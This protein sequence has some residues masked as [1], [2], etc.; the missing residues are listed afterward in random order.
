MD[1]SA[2][3][4]SKN[5]SQRTVQVARDKT[6]LDAARAAGIEIHATCGSRGRCRSCR[7][8][9]LKGAA[10][11]PTVQDSVQLGHDEVHEGFR[12]ACQTRMLG[13]TTIRA[14][15]PKEE[16]GHQILHSSDSQIEGRGMHIESGV[17]KRVIHAKAPVEEHHQT[18]DIEEILSVLPDL[19]SQEI[20]VHT[21][22]KTPQLLRQCGGQLTIT[23]FND[24]VI[25]IEAGDTTDRL[26]GMAIDIGTTSVVATLLDLSSGEQLAS[27]GGVNE[28]SQYGGDLMS[29]IAY[30]QFNERH[31]ATL[32]AKVINQVNQYVRQTCKAAKVSESNVYKIVV[33]GNTCM[34]HIFLGIDVS[35]VGLAPYAPVVR[36]NLVIAS[37]ELPLKSAPTRKFACCRSS[38]ASSAPTLSDAYC[39]LEFMKARPVAHWSTSAQTAK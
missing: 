14:M 31:L 34:H 30:A 13:D 10:P 25:D 23:T 2:T 27:A 20:P 1:I 18:S 37:S 29:R 6:I 32:R 26:Y 39:P 19:A 5:G 28:Q 3:F 22:R 38:P 33:V 12:L 7:V 9:I 16:A 24:R 11:P 21:I 35:H 36:G 17:K 15:P 4:A 8:K